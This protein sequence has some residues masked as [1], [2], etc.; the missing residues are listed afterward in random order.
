[1]KDKNYL[2]QIYKRL[3]IE[4]SMKHNSCVKKYQKFKNFKIG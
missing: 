4:L 2:E 3:D 1:M